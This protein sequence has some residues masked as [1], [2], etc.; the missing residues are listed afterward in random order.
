MDLTFTAR[1]WFISYASICSEPNGDT[2]EFQIF[3]DFRVADAINSAG[4]QSLDGSLICY[5]WF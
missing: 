4:D 5:W 1:R 2:I 3:E